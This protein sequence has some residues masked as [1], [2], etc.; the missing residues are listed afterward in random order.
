MAKAKT[1]ITKTKGRFRIDV[2]DSRGKRHRPAFD[3]KEEAIA[4]IDRIEANKSSGEFLADASKVTFNKAL[5]LFLERNLREGLAQSSRRRVEYVIK[6]HLRPTFGAR[7]LRDFRSQRMKFVQDWLDHR[8]RDHGVASMT[9]AHTLSYIK[10]ALDEAIKAGLL[11]SP[12]PVTEFNVRV[13]QF[14]K[15]EEREVLTLDEI[16]KLISVALRRE[17]AEH[18]PAF[19]VR[20]L[21]VLFGL[22]LGLRDQE[23]GAVCWDCVNLEDRLIHIRRKIE[24]GVLVNS[25]KTGKS[26][27]RSIPMSP[28]LYAA[29]SAYRDELQ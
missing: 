15:R 19:R 25:T 13:P 20:F 1:K 3:T 12:N 14:V 21:L 18:E 2:L 10:Q 5:D 26:G 23:C 24:N 27:F 7:K 6:G 4:A 17:H 11:G 22:L 29:L 9:L 8:S 16:S 28:I